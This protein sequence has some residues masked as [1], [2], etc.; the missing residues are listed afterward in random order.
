MKVSFAFR[1]IGWAEDTIQG[2]KMVVSTQNE[3]EVIISHDED[4]DEDE[5]KVGDEDGAA[6]DLDS[7]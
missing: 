4:E 5:D 6:T 2:K 3:F 1:D 7:I